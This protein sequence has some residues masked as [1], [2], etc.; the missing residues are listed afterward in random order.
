[1]QQFPDRPWTVTALAREAA[2]SRSAFF[3]RF[4]SIVGMPPMMYLLS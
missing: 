1:M 3:E 4:S 2:L